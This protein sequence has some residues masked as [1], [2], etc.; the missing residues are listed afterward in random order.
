MQDG[1]RTVDSQ[2]RTVFNYKFQMQAV[3]EGGAAANI[4]IA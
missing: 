3:T 2:R 4:A 1:M